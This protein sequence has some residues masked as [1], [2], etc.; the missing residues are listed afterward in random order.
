VSPV[1]TAVISN[2]SAIIAAI[3]GMRPILRYQ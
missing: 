1:M 3:N 2:G